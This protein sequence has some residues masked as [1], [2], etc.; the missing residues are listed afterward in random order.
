MRSATETV[1]WQNRLGTVITP[2]LFMQSGC[3]FVLVSMKSRRATSHR[4]H[5]NLSLQPLARTAT[6]HRLHAT[7]KHGTYKGWLQCER[8]PFVSSWISHDK[9]FFVCSRQRAREVV[10]KIVALKSNDIMRRRHTFACSENKLNT[11]QKIN[12]NKYLNRQ[13]R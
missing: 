9:A 10:N 2:P 5:Q 13:W 11:R 1:G 12:R 3:D 4:W 8:A 6:I 7:M